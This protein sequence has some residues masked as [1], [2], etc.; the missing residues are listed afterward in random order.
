MNEQLTIRSFGPI[1]EMN[2]TIRDFT[3]FIGPQGSGKS[4]ASKVLTICHDLSWYLHVLDEDDGVF[5]PF[6]KFCIEEYFNEATYI[7]FVDSSGEV[8]IVYADGKFVLNC[9]GLSKQDAKD[10]ISKK[11]LEEN[12]VFLAKLGVA[13]VSP[14]ELEDR[15]AQLLR[16]NARM[17][18]YIPAERNL[19]GSL[20]N[21][22]ASVI[23]SNIPLYDALLEYMSVY[24]RAK[25]ELKEYYV[26]FLDVSY[27][28]TDGK[29][30]IWLG[31]GD[32]K[33]KPLPL[34]ACSSGLQSVLPLLMS[35]DYALRT[36]S[37]DAFVIEEPE[38]NLFPANQRALMQHLVSFYNIA[39]VFGMV[40]TT[41]SPYIL[42]CMNIMMLAGKI[43]NKYDLFEEVIGITG[44]YHYINPEDVSVYRLD[45]HADVFCQDLKNPKT[46]LIGVNALDSASEFI[47]E[48]YDRLYQ[49]YVNELKKK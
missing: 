37:F 18:L 44:E 11:I 16:A 20:S 24:E 30:K 27:A 9:D 48:D 3:I 39:N 4:T 29:E 19:A 38:Q 12:K 47:G 41:H 6:N 45:P 7:R 31:Q 5:V 43:I 25:N 40:L 22:L 33:R 28:T 42:S 34:S 17:M 49:L 13:D 26:P 35:L 8:V 15:Y 36:V 1:K 23:A 46:G 2:V 32:N 10:M 14:S 21:S